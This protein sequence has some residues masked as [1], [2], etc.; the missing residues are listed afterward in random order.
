MDAVQSYIR[1]CYHPVKC[2]PS[3]HRLEN[4]YI[5]RASVAA[6]VEFLVAFISGIRK[7]NTDQQIDSKCGYKHIQSKDIKFIKF[8]VS[9][10]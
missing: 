2:Y 9:I 7:S 6:R 3:K 4:D 10:V 5:F 1:S 8:N